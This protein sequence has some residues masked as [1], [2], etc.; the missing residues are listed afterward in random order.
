MDGG[1]LEAEP[2]DAGGFEAGVLAVVETPAFS[3]ALE[4]GL[5]GTST[6]LES[7]EDWPSGLHLPPSH[8]FTQSTFK[9]SKVPGT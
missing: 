3:G 1:G 8:N 4:A 2:V 6:S 5:S 7:D 9:F